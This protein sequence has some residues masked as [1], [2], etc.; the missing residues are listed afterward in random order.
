[1]SDGRLTAFWSH[2]ELDTGAYAS[3]GPTVANRVPV[4]ASGPYLVPHAAT[5]GTAY[6][7][8]APPSGAFRGFGVPQSAIAS[9]AA[10]DMLADKLGMDWLEF[11]RIN[12]LR[13]GD[14]TTTGQR[15]DSSVGIVASIDAVEPFWR[16]WTTQAD[17]FN[18]AQRRSQAR[19]RHRL[20]LVRHRQYVIVEPLRDAYRHRSVRPGHALQRRRRH[21]PGLEHHHGAD[22]RRCIGR[23]G[24]EHPPRRRRHRPHPRRRQDQRLA[25]DLRF[26][27]GVPARRAR[28]APAA[29]RSWR[30][31]RSIWSRM[32]R[33][34][35][36]S[37][38]AKSRLPPCRQRTAAGSL[39][40]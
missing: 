8:N 24:V 20:L 28:S 21:R 17:A 5:R 12:A 29:V 18:E 34:D 19:R 10:M 3:W 13:A 27:Q 15:L 36:R 35:W 2:A 31:H 26:R 7:T 39:R 37:K 22:R 23:S 32:R 25:P 4:H 16:D 40:P 38:P 9:E 6:F 30:E 1:M 11:R 14:T 33:C